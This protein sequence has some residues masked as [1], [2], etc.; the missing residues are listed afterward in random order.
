MRKNSGNNNGVCRYVGAKA[1]TDRYSQIQVLAIQALLLVSDH[2]ESIVIQNWLRSKQLKL[3]SCTTTAKQKWIDGVC[4][5]WAGRDFWANLDVGIEREYLHT[6]IC[7]SEPL[8][9]YNWTTLTIMS[10]SIFIGYDPSFEVEATEKNVPKFC[11]Q[12]F[13][14]WRKLCPKW[15]TNPIAINRFFPIVQWTLPYTNH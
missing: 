10:F 12:L 5:C 9:N 11:K 6:Y 7:V 13:F 15:S 4:L 2:F 14:G 8:L 1:L 3:I